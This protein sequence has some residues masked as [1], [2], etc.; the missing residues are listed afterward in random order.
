MKVSSGKQ[1]QAAVFDSVRATPFS[2]IPGRL[3]CRDCIT[4]RN[5]ACEAA[6][7]IDSEYD[8]AGD[9][10]HLA[11]VTGDAEYL[12]ITTAA[13]TPLE[14]AVETAPVAF[15]PAINQATTD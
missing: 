10:G 11:I 14:Y 6:C 8:W 7:N 1:A 9:F 3:T 4:L 13:G 2:R 15:N 5:K 12:T